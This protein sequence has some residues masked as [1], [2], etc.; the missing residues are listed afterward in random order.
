MFDQ[1]QVAVSQLGVVL[2]V[3]NLVLQ[4]EI[5]QV[6]N[7]ELSAAF[8]LKEL[9]DFTGEERWACVEFSQAVQGETGFFFEDPGEF[10]VYELVLSHVL[11]IKFFTDFI[12]VF[13]VYLEP[14]FWFDWAGEVVFDEV[15]EAFVFFFM[16]KE[17]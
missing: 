13:D 15:E 12:H 4:R 3:F 16:K 2:G 17:N 1:K 7:A 11:S 5:L 9:P 8:G 14:D 6:L 10:F